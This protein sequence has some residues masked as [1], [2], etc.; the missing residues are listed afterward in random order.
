MSFITTTPPCDAKG[1]VA[2]LYRQ[3]QA[4]WGFV[5]NYAQAFCHRPAVL[6]RWAQ[7]LAEIRRPMGARLFELATFAAA[8]ELRHSACTL[9]HGLKLRE[10]FSDPEIAALAAGG[11]PE[12]L[13]AAEH[14]AMHFAR[15]VA[16]DAST[17]TQHDVLALKQAGLSDAEVFD[18][19]AA[20][21]GRAFF[22]KLLDALGVLADAPL[23]GFDEPL[24]STLTVGR[25]IDTRPCA[26]LPVAGSGDDADASA[27]GG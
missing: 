14:L 6:S 13:G 22:T 27:R 20:A 18:V 10:F 19:A 3:Q 9:A 21:A 1:E 5:P 4:A 23:A 16:R 8:I 11:A 2:A 12:G 15:R 17:I 7:L 25:P 26:T 24:R